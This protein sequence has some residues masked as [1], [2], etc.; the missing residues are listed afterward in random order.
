MFELTQK[1][2]L[3]H[4]L[5]IIKQ[6]NVRFPVAV[7]SKEF[8]I[9]KGQISHMLRGLTNIPDKFWDAFEKKYPVGSNFRPPVGEGEQMKIDIQI[10]FNAV[11]QINATLSGESVQKELKQLHDLRKIKN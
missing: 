1:Q 9:T 5:S 6:N 8:D 10:L 4:V 11:A 7:L 2:K 3:E